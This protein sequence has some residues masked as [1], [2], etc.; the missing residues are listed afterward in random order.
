MK[1]F[2]IATL[3][4]KVN[5]YESH[6]LREAWL[7]D[8]WAEVASAEEAGRIIVN[9]CAVTAKAVADVR[10]T[11]RRLHRASPEAKIIVTGCAAQ[12]LAKEL[13]ELPGVSKVIPQEHKALL[14]PVRDTET[15][16]T[17]PQEEEKDTKRFP[18]FHLSG[19]DRSR[20]VLKIQDGCSHRCTYCIVPLTR[21]NARSRN[22]DA[23]L[24]EMRRLLQAGFR[25]ITIS[26]VNL[27]QYRDD[28]KRD[29]WDF[30]AALEKALAPE[31]AGKARLRIS[32]L[33]PGQLTSKALDVLGGSRLVTPHLH[34]SLQSGSA[35]VLQRMGRGHYDLASVP[36]FLR[37]LRTYWP[38]FGLGADIL[39]GFPGETEEE[40]SEGLEFCRSL[41]LSYAHVFPYSKR[42]GTPAATLPGQVSSGVKKERAALLRHMVVAKKERFLQ[43][44]L[45]LEQMHVVFE[46]REGGKKTGIVQGINEFY[47]DCRLEATK[48]AAALLQPGEVPAGKANPGGWSP[49]RETAGELTAVRAV[50]VTGHTL[51]VRL[52]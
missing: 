21:G 2:F 36:A 49:D 18:P 20:A 22:F 15:R 24:A 12:V 6:S 45:S 26:G 35:T 50:G 19:Y 5:Q 44:L 31:W 37:Q 48:N 17:L 25:E 38:V 47:A 8:G 23:S 29:F 11:V 39:T 40:F 1:R 51:Q 52:L 13:A 41:P 27:R 3:G 9:S 30:L 34:L 32:S 14:L 28:G 46:A 10:N 16:N 42:P 43:S 4:C 7:A 33:E